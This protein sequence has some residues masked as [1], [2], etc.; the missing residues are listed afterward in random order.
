[1]L[2]PISML[3][4]EVRA[5]DPPG[6]IP[7]DWLLVTFL[8]II[9]ILEGIFID[10]LMWRSLTIVLTVT[11]T[12]TLPWRRTHPLFMAIV[13]YGSSAVVQTVAIIADVEW[14]GL[15]CNIFVV[16]FPYSLLRWGSG[17]EAIIGLIAIAMAITPA[18]AVETRSWLEIL[19]ASMFILI[20][21]GLGVFVRYQDNTQRRISQNVRSQERELLARELY[22]TVAHHVSAIAIQAQAGR[23]LA[24]TQPNAPLE[25]LAVIEESASRT[26][27]EMR[28]IVSMLRDDSDAIRAPIETLN[29][30]KQLAQDNA[31]PL[32]VTINFEGELNSLSSTLQS[33]LYRLTQEALTNA[34]RHATDAHS[35]DIL[36]E[37]N[38]SE[39]RLSVIDDGQFIAHQPPAGHGLRGMG[40]RVAL[41]GGTLRSRPGGKYGWSVTATLPKYRTND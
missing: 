10:S 24:D 34:V 4:H 40:E 15:T 23:A 11:L 35:V 29:D 5:P 1:M 36:I 16:I 38:D 32:H 8:A 21:A 14:R 41:L 30:I 28:Q 33:T 3:W 18:M 27:T 13:A 7:R 6:P 37:G 22:D 20:P 19:G 9:A 25:T 26:L 31:Y 2:K 39:V 12:L 17:R